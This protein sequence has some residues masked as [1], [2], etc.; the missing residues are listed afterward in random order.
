ML[1]TA[2]VVVLGLAAA[3]GAGAFAVWGPAA[4]AAGT[5]LPAAVVLAGIVV[6]CTI[7]GTA[8][9][10]ACRM[11]QQHGREVAELG[12]LD[13]SRADLPPGLG[14]VGGVAFLVARSVA[15]A[16]AAAVFGSYVLPAQPLPTAIAAIVVATAANVAGVRW[17]ARG[18]YALVGGTVAVLLF[19]VVI[20][21]L[22]D[23]DGRIA[24]AAAARPDAV[25]TGGGPLGI[26]CAA[27]FVCFAF[28][29]AAR[30]AVLGEASRRP[31]VTLR[32]AVPLAV[33][34]AVAVYLLVTVA[35]LV[36]MG[37]DRLAVETAPLAA[38][39]DAGR[40]PA[41][42]VLVRVG[43]AVAAGSALLS[44]LIGLSRTMVTMARS[45]ELPV[46]LSVTGTR[47]RPVRADLVGGA[48][49]VAV[50]CVAGQAATIAV[51]ACSVLIAYAVVNVA[52]L[53]MPAGA[54]RWPRW[55]SALGAVL[56]VVLAAAL[57]L[58]TVVVA[59]ALTAVGW[60]ACTVRVTR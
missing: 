15:A 20:G 50:V 43:A 12:A 52:A 11:P 4:A 48:V 19:A 41:L 25:P 53:R 21:L 47:G 46:A 16:A 58:P 28:A 14:R 29:G 6:A 34:I 60:A 59:V 1:G 37:A 24:S 26:A 45:G 2:D 54:R 44:I 39:V 22:A 40:A 38:V 36:G 49:A 9:L 35:L 57:P 56:A 30:V 13:I 17:T 5:W 33:G 10:V 31:E 32:R 7:T 18:S 51:A 55:S 8:D 27:G 23:G 3:F 42:G